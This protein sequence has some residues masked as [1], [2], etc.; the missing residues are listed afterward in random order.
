MKRKNPVMVEA[1]KK[2]QETRRRNKAQRLRATV[3]AYL[4]PQEWAWHEDNP[5]GIRANRKR[6]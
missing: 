2:A 1:G 4:S 5:C 3:Y 6:K